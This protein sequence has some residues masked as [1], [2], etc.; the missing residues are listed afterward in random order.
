[1]K[2]GCATR[3]S[4]GPWR[5]ER[6]A[7]SE[8]SGSGGDPGRGVDARRSSAQAPQPWPGA[9]RAA[10]I[11]ALVVTTTCLAAKVDAAPLDEGRSWRQGRGDPS[12]R[13]RS[14]GGA[15]LSQAPVARWRLP[16]DSRPASAH[17]LDV[18]LLSGDEIIG[19]EAGAVVAR[20]VYGVLRWRT[21]A[22]GAQMIWRV[23]DLD[24]DS[25]GELWVSCLDGGRVIDVGSGAT[26]FATPAGGF[27]ELARLEAADVDGDGDLEVL[28]GNSGG[29]AVV[30]S[31]RTWVFDASG[32][33]IGAT[34]EIDPNGMPA[35][36]ETCGVVDLD[37]DG[38][39]DLLCGSTKV[40]GGGRM[41]AWRLRDQTLLAQGAE[42]EGRHCTQVRAVERPGRKPLALCASDST[43][44]QFAWHGVAAFGL[45][46]GAIQRLWLYEPAPQSEARIGG[47]M[48][49]DLDGDGLH[50]V[51]LGQRVGGLGELVALDVD[52]GKALPGG[53]ALPRLRVGQGVGGALL[54]VAPPTTSPGP[55]ALT[56]ARWRREKG[57]SPLLTI[58]Q[59]QAGVA[60]VTTPTQPGAVWT[61]ADL[62]GD[63]F[64]ETARWL[65]IVASGEV[66]ARKQRVF[67][68]RPQF[69]A[70][71][72]GTDG[73]PRLLISERDGGCHW[74]DLDSA[75]GNDVAADGR[76]DLVIRSLSTPHLSVGHGRVEGDGGARLVSVGEPG[77][78]RVFDARAGDPVTTPPM[79]LQIELPGGAL[80]ANLADVDGDG[81]R[82]VVVRNHPPAGDATLRALELDGAT[83]WSV[84]AP[85]DRLVWPG[86][87]DSR[88]IADVNGDG[89]EDLGVGWLPGPGAVL[90]WQGRWI[91]GKDGAAV[92]P[93][94]TPCGE[95]L[96]RTAALDLSGGSAVTWGAIFLDRLRCSVPGGALL[97]KVTQPGQAATYGTGMVGDLDGLP[98]AE[99]VWS[100]AFNAL[101]AETAAGPPLWSLTG[102]QYAGR[103]ATQLD[104]D[105]KP[106]FITRAGA[107]ALIA[108]D[109]AKGA[110][111]WSRY[112]ASGA[113]LPSEA[114]ATATSL[115]GLVGVQG[116]FA[117]GEPG[118]VISCA[119]GHLLGVDA[120]DGGVRW[121]RDYGARLGV[122]IAADIDA[123]ADV[124]LLV[125]TPN[126]TL[127]A[128][129]RDVLAKV[130]WVRDNDGAG[131]AASDTDDIDQGESTERLH[132]NW[133][134]TPGAAGY[135]VRVLD[136]FG[137][138]ISGRRDVGA[139]TS[140][141]V[142]GLQ[143]QPL[144]QYR[145]EVTAYATHDGAG[146]ESQAALSDGVSIVDVSPPE[147]VS[148][149]ATPE[150]AVAGTPI[151]L[152]MTA[153]D[154][155]R[156]AQLRLQVLDGD[157]ALLGEVVTQAASREASAELSFVAVDAEGEPLPEGAYQV[158]AV[159]RDVGGHEAKTALSFALCAAGSA[160]A[161]LGRGA[162]G[163][164]T[165]EPSAAI[166]KAEQTD[167]ACRAGGGRRA[168]SPGGI[169]LLCSLIAAILARRARAQPSG[170]RVCSKAQRA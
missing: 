81:A 124:E 104:V 99:V 15:R 133:A 58:G 31:G 151:A 160:G 65:E 47:L 25:R 126:G 44:G 71:G 69:A 23:A 80:Q 108:L 168:P 87:V 152:Q 98:G 161:A 143:L 139:V 75:T 35:F 79:T 21:A 167:C 33:T 6:V 13:N 142:A 93:E 18:D 109:G 155:T 111:A 137:G 127:E 106:R 105:G 103:P 166:G 100:G 48:V 39:A 27:G 2:T 37:G 66:I 5:I 70:S 55:E 148:L 76:P 170:G 20:D 14:L 131:P 116:L 83:R 73:A 86:G 96:T 130:A 1:M 32:A 38:G 92:V 157:G 112:Y 56:L 40:L 132:A 138:E 147:I 51:L 54:L 135:H 122:P 30:H 16:L 163:P 9:R 117:D 17:A 84:V 158:A 154:A 115:V 59:V 159:A 129:D 125:P 95:L 77:R 60:R 24:G 94:H 52:D 153:R 62:D 4:G 3:S 169:A 85:D 90:P 19:V 123:D 150:L 50:E 68:G 34:P 63:G 141:T 149:T 53:K 78:L 67:D 57:L 97:T 162:C 107:A 43:N 144:A 61:L 74:L 7:S 36:A 128:L 12:Q 8:R 113:A 165:G 102:K 45:V 42:G 134:V 10:R 26:R 156:L 110:I 29:F 46:G 49:D 145:V 120:R 121:S 91:L 82:E 89:A 41:F 72:E 88:L 101:A 140:A 11:V 164:L 118:V 136:A 28:A 114:T 146:V 119:D 22:I 64:A